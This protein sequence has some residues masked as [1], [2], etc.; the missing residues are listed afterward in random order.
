MGSVQLPPPSL[1]WWVSLV[2][3]ILP[4]V[5]SWLF[6]WLATVGIHPLEHSE[7]HGSWS[8]TYKK[9]GTKKRFCVQKP[10]GP[11]W[12]QLHVIIYL[13]KLV[14]YTVPR[15]NLNIKVLL[16]SH[17]LLFATLW[18]VARQTPLSMEFSRQE[19]W[20]RLPFSSSGDLPYPGIKPGSSA[21]QAD[22][23]P[24]E[25]PGKSNFNIA[26]ELWVIIMFQCRFIC[27]SM[28]K[29][30]TLCD[31]M[32]RSMPGF[33]VLH[34]VPEFA[35]THVHWVS[36]TIQ[37]SV[38]CRPLLSPSPAFNLSQHQAPF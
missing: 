5:I 23:V 3:L 33:P 11:P 13:S 10:T 30:P 22:S 28:T 31:P 32:D 34:H 6:P 37:P 38:F 36:D 17:V 29:C 21:L 24:S 20:S 18:T 7:N 14:Q 1:S 4:Q 16:L 35:Q 15:I 27:C 8:L 26:Y 19:Y 9:W 25:P 2:P 12:F